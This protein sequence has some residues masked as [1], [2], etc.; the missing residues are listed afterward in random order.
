MSLRTFNHE[1]HEAI[2]EHE[3]GSTL[4]VLFDFFVPFVVTDQ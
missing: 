1:A 2:E 3:E 4:F